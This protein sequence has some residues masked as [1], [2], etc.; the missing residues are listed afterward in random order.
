MPGR[1]ASTKHFSS[2]MFGQLSQSTACNQLLRTMMPSGVI[3]AGLLR[4]L[5]GAWA[6][7]LKASKNMVIEV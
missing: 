1:K 6:D 2:A 5:F 3:N 7:L 4:F